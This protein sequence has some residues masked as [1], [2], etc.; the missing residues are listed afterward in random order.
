MRFLADWLAWAD[1]QSTS[2]DLELFLFHIL[3]VLNFF[4]AIKPVCLMKSAAQST[5]RIFFIF[6]AKVFSDFIPDL[7]SL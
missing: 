1:I 4:S 5:T 2:S 3:Y 6:K 7:F